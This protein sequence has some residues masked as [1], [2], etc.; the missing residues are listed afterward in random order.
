M[1]AVAAIAIYVGILAFYAYSTANRKDT[2]ASVN[3]GTNNSIA[4]N[5][6]MIPPSDQ[7]TLQVLDNNG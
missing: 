1:V 4:Q 5:V 3:P 6:T 7:V 2:V